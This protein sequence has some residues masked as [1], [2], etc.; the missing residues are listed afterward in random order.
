MRLRLAI[1][2]LSLCSQATAQTYVEYLANS[3]IAVFPAIREAVARTLPPDKAALVRATQF[4]IAPA[5]PKKS[6]CGMHTMYASRNSAGA[7]EITLCPTGYRM[8]VDLAASAGYYF[9]HESFSNEINF[10]SNLNQINEVANRYISFIN[11]HQAYLTSQYFRITSEATPDSYPKIC[12]PDVFTYLY[13]NQISFEK[14]KDY[15]K[16]SVNWLYTDNSNG[17]LTDKKIESKLPNP[18]LLRKPPK[19]T[20]KHR[21]RIIK[22]IQTEL[23]SGVWLGQVLHEF[24]HIINGDLDSPAG[25]HADSLRRELQADQDAVVLLTTHFKRGEPEDL[26]RLAGLMLAQTFALTANN[27]ETFKDR[28]P[29]TFVRAFDKF[30]KSKPEMPPELAQALF[31][32]MKDICL[33]AKCPTEIQ[34]SLEN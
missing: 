20:P 34:R 8:A 12:R 1:A 23:F 31:S 14:C 3:H 9:I 18:L 2:L 28:L 5:D 27:P 25:D 7:P 15:D 13:I 29:E 30:V 6:D 26:F 16:E 21:H 4:K 22:D 19:L 33:E 11:S 32:A 10:K 24:S 17:I